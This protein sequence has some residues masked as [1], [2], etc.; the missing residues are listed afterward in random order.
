MAIHI[1]Y[2]SKSCRRLHFTF[3][4]FWKPEDESVYVGR[5]DRQVNLRGFRFDLDDVEARIL[6]AIPETSAI[7][8][9]LKGQYII[10]LAQ[11]ES[12]SVMRLRSRI[13]ETLVPYARL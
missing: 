6:K 7:A 5:K 2:F 11:P 4:Y 12:A 3:P 9:T 1:T 8:L 13:A 10:A